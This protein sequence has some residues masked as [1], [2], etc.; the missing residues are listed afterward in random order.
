[1]ATRPSARRIGGFTLIELV[2]VVSIASILVSIMAPSF[3]PTPSVQV[4][5]MTR[6]L[7]G[8]LEMARTYALAQRAAVEVVFDESL[9]TYTGYMDH[10]NDG[11]IMR[12]AAEM[13]AFQSF[14]A[15]EI[16]A[17]IRFGRGNAA[18]V[19]TDPSNDPITLTGNVL[20]LDVQ[21]VPDP[22][23]TMGTIYLVHRDDANAVGAVS[24]AASGS[25]KAW[26]WYPGD[27]EW[28]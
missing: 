12:I 26:R 7:A 16:E 14:G 21:G 13:S 24:I 10:D 3:Q 1:M 5:R 23:G 27:E 17:P 25:F 8:H 11:V 2:L 18:K 4:Q 9:L 19:P 28:R 6:L 20:D 15:R 22:W